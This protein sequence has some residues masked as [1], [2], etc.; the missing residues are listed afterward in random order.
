[1]AAAAPVDGKGGAK[2]GGPVNG[3]VNGSLKP[4][5]VSIASLASSPASSTL[6]MKKERQA[7]ALQVKGVRQ[8]SHYPLAQK[9]EQSSPQKSKPLEQQ[10][11]EVQ[12]KQEVV[13][14]QSVKLEPEESHTVKLEPRDPH[15]VKQEHQASDTAAKRKR[16]VQSLAA[17]SL[18]VPS[19]A[20]LHP[21]MDRARTTGLSTIANLRNAQDY[22]KEKRKPLP[23]KDIASYLSLQH[24][25]TEVQVHFRA[26]LRA[27]PKVHFDNGLF[28]YKPTL[29]F[30]D[31]EGMRAY[32]R[33]QSVA[34]GVRI[35]D[36]KDGWPACGDEIDRMMRDHETLLLRD[37]RGLARAAHADEPELWPPPPPEED[38]DFNME[39]DME[40]R[41]E[42]A[43]TPNGTST[44]LAPIQTVAWKEVKLPRTPDD[45]RVK[46]KYA[47]L[48]TTTAAKEKNKLF[49]KKVVKKKAHKRGGRTTNIHIQHL[50]KD[51]SK[52]T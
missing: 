1:M 25:P 8:T 43:S 48:R 11:A 45:M 13:E 32:M 29:P 50:L 40:S 18:A 39:S 23:F 34:G 4:N 19:V 31:A 15:A 30:A 9:P 36:V 27:D 12:I 6:V 22:L 52:R 51:Y 46:L 42:A 41:T 14:V 38:D 17:P 2:G 35:D 33:V 16:Y 20:T 47:G 21:D 3:H 44:P 37:R 7:E 49:A 28:S 24:A 10:P 26:L 5:G